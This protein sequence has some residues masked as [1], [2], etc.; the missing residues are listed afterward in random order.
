MKAGT[1]FTTSKSM[2]SMKTLVC[3]LSAPPHVPA[4]IAVSWGVA[5]FRARTEENAEVLSWYGAC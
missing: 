2:P 3:V 5:A 4:L 1:S